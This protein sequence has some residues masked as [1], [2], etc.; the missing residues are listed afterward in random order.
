MRTRTTARARGPLLM[1]PARTS[2]SRTSLL[3]TVASF[4]DIWPEL[5][6]LRSDCRATDDVLLDPVHF[7]AATSRERRP[8]SVACWDGQRLAGVLFATEHRVH[9]F[10][11]GYAIGGDFSGRGL[12]L[13][14]PEDE[15]AVIESAVHCIF[16]HGVHSLHLRM[17]PRSADSPDLR[18]LTTKYLTKS[19]EGVIPGDRMNLLSGYEQFLSTLGKHTRRNVRYYTRK[20]VD[21]GIQFEPR[22]DEEEFNRAR[23]RLNREAHFAA[24]REH[25]RRDDRLLA[26]HSDSQ[27]MGLRDRSGDLV[28]LLCGF[29]MQRRFHL[30]T[31][32][33]DPRHEKLSLSLV[34]RGFAVQHL[35]SRG[36][37]ELVF[38]G[39]TSLSFGRFCAPHRYCSLLLDRSTGPV[40]LAKRVLAGYA[41]RRDRAGRPLP[42]TIETLAGGLLCDARLA[43]RTALNPASI[44]FPA[45][46]PRESAAEEQLL[47]PAPQVTG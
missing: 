38:M 41:L 29:T 33:N 16:S 12:V 42:Y 21:A 27:R 39:G 9:G 17:A 15:A 3:G 5:D 26:L 36:H 18:G 31:Q 22:V 13:C 10:R 19:L 11:T 20:A 35:I 30:L 47:S 40:R 46:P 28:A 32:W 14:R 37:N 6:Q 23:Q 43:V 2:F 7:L 25:L 24:A 45:Q 8:C 44:A 4:V 34:L 1:T